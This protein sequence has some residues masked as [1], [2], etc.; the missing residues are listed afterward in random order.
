MT[1]ENEDLSQDMRYRVP[2][3]HETEHIIRVVGSDGMI[4]DV[5]MTD[6]QLKETLHFIRTS[7]DS[8]IKRS[9]NDVALELLHMGVVKVVHR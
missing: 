2:A 4:C 3:S 1:T 8:T 9:F 7:K 5:A 6:A